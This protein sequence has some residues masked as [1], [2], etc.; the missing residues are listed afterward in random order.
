MWFAETQESLDQGNPVNLNQV[1][2][3]MAYGT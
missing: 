3:Q 2:V 1:N